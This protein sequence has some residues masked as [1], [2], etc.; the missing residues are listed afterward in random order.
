MP[1]LLLFNMERERERE[2]EREFIPIFQLM[3]SIAHDIQ[4]LGIKII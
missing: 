1:Y 2:R 3:T 4:T